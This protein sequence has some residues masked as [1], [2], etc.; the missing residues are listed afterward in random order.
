MLE[1]IQ[2]DAKGAALI[3]AGLYDEFSNLIPSQGKVLLSAIA[4]TLSKPVQLSP[5]QIQAVLTA[6]GPGRFTVTARAGKLEKTV[7]VLI[8]EVSWTSGR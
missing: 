4:G 2:A 6:R 8:P 3:T 1:T 7:E 5:G